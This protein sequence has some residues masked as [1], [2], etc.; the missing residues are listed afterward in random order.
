M[1]QERK[2]EKL[3]KKIRMPKAAQTAHKESEQEEN[4]CIFVQDDFTEK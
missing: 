4:P 1:W 3:A 2:K